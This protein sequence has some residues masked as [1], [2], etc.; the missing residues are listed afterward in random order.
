MKRPDTA[1][2]SDGT[3]GSLVV[4]ID[5]T[6]PRAVKK[7]GIEVYKITYHFPCYSV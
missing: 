7:G 4:C 5:E 2:D 1:E 3:R 6:V